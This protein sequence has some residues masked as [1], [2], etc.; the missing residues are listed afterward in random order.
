M[1]LFL[2]DMSLVSLVGSALE[3]VRTCELSLCA[4]CK[5]WVQVL[6]SINFIIT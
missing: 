4:S 5:R 2:I 6:S 3:K 1:Q